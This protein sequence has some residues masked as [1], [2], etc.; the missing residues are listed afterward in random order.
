[1]KPLFILIL[2][3]LLMVT[4]NRAGAA[5]KMVVAELFTTT[6]CPSCPTAED[7]ITKLTQEKGPS[8]LFFLAWHPTSDEFGNDKLDDYI[9]NVNHVHGIPTICFDGISS[10]IGTR[11]GLAKTYANLYKIRAEKTTGVAIELSGESFDTT[12]KIRA[13]I[14]VEKKSTIPGNNILFALYEIK[15]LGKKKIFPNVVRDYQFYS[16]NIRP[17]ET[18][19]VPITFILP[20][21]ADPYNFG[22]AVLLKNSTTN[23]ILNS[24]VISFASN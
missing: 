14:S 3:M 21:G 7:A 13:R 9:E 2:S 12:L 24:G 6:W 20:Q 22:I 16:L 1:M 18:K 11:W 19:T 8:K 15:A 5:E 4:G 10:V 17:G 23:E